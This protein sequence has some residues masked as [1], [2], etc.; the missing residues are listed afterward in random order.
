[1]L[2]NFQHGKEFSCFEGQTSE[3]VTGMFGLFRMSQLQFPMETIMEEAREFSLK[4][5]RDKQA[6][7]K[8]I[9]KWIITKDLP[10]EVIEIELKIL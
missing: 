4:F 9:D 2:Q 10:G 8:L 7:A 5:L 6:C 3:S 1:M